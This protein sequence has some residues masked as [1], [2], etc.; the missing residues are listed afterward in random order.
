MKQPNLIW[1]NITRRY[2]SDTWV[3]NEIGA[4]NTLTKQQE[5]LPV[6]VEQARAQ[7][8]R[9]KL[10]SLSTAKKGQSIVST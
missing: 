9:L 6:S 3:K 2:L 10:Q 7:V 5:L 8:Q 4:M 1:K